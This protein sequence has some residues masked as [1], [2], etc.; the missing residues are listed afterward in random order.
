MWSSELK[1][2]PEDADI[3]VSIGSMFLTIGELDL[4]TH[5]LLNAVDLDRANA[6]TYYYL[7]LASAH[8][9]RLENAA[10][11][12]AHALDINSDHIEALRDSSFIYLKMGRLEKAEERINKARVLNDD[13][14]QLKAL[15]RRIHLARIMEQTGDFI[16][17]FIPRCLLKKLLP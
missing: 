11:F 17:R 4:S 10:E 14:L 8:K 1:R 3:L 15:A 13:D 2:A 9:G 6:D 12:F 5:C 7:G 16:L